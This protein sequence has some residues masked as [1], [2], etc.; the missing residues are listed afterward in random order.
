MKYF[1]TKL[2]LMA[3]LVIF[4]LLQGGLI[5][6]SAQDT[7]SYD[8][9]FGNLLVS[10]NTLCVDIQIRAATDIQFT[11]GS[12]TLSLSYNKDNLSNPIYTSKNFDNKNLCAMGNTIAPYFAP[13]V[14]YDQE[15]GT[16]NIATNI[17]IPKYGCPK[18]TQDWLTA[19]TIC[20]EM[21]SDIQPTAF[22][23]NKDLTLITPDGSTNLKNNSMSD[24]DTIP[25]STS[26]DTDKDG[27]SDNDES[28]YGT[29]A[30]DP[31]S[32]NDGLLDGQELIIVKTDPLNP[33]TDGDTVA[34][35]LEAPSGQKIDTDG[36]SIIDALDK[37]DD[38]DNI[39]TANEDPNNDKNPTND[40]TDDDKI[41]NYLDNND[42]NDPIL[43]KNEDTNKDGNFSNDDDDGDGIPDYLDPDQVGISGINVIGAKAFPNPANE[44]LNIEI[45]SQYAQ[46]IQKVQLIN[47]AGQI[48]LTSKN[49]HQLSL[50]NIAAGNYQISFIGYDQQI[51]G[52]LTIT[53]Q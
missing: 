52:K 53:K 32:D 43:T 29:D 13:L 7:A 18:V 41:P 4:M 14:N 47:Q 49:Y 21:I 23:W 24:L 36:D 6:L 11:I 16:F 37:D 26:K 38:N 27:L 28:K 19:G 8:L 12:H 31:D 9:K 25:T 34:D 20:F 33:D 45:D 48:V 39:P 42:D 44:F 22:Y 2:A 40:D 51:L 3:A 35:G 10:G 1:F 30:S 50:H 46:Q 15:A 17:I 5:K